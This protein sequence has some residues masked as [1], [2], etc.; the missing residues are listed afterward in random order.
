M[1][2]HMGLGGNAYHVS[3]DMPIS[4]KLIN[5]YGLMGMYSMLLGLEKRST[6]V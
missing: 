4:S 1:A 2:Q 5:L 6:D 3:H